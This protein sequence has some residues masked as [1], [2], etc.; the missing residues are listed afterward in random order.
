MARNEAKNFFTIKKH[1]LLNKIKL[2][3]MSEL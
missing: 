1:M 2:K 3:K